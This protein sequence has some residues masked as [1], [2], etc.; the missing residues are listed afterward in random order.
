MFKP[1]GQPQAQ[2]EETSLGISATFCVGMQ[3]V[4]WLVLEPTPLKNIK[5]NWD[6]DIANRWKNNPNVPNRQ[7]VNIWWNYDTY[8]IRLIVFNTCGI[9][10]E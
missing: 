9:C 3:H 8:M 5:V 7:P 10:S 4:N 2:D 1:M 6:D